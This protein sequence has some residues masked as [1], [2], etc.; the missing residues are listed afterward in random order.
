MTH[1]SNGSHAHVG[2]DETGQTVDEPRAKTIGEGPSI[3][4]GAEIVIVPFHGEHLQA[5]QDEGGGTVWVIVKRVCDALGLLAHPQ[6]E[7]LQ[8]KGWATTR[9][10]RVV[11]EDGKT[12]EMF[13]I[14]LDSLPMWLAT[15]EPSRVA[16]HVRPKLLVFQ[17]ECARAL[18]D[19]FFGRRRDSKD[20]QAFRSSVEALMATMGQTI[21]AL[22]DEVR[23]L[24]TDRSHDKGVIG[25][26]AARTVV[27]DPLLKIAEL[28]AY[29]AGE[30]RKAKSFRQKL[31]NLL[32][33][34]LGF[35]ISPGQGWAFL[36]ET[37]RGQATATIEMLKARQGKDFDKVF[38]QMR[39]A[40]GQ[41]SF[42]D[43]LD[44]MAAT[45]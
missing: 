1:D 14:S 27:L 31:D 39:A 2:N 22:T 17:K 44:Q 28:M 4:G 6:A 43:F 33:R 8:S 3:A 21:A 38:V 26:L 20:E 32:R 41:T 40:K 30:P 13:C 29:Q 19:H 7:K 11:A 24:R 25:T 23:A 37:K 9:M 35:P 12:R 5:T 42:H 36:P 10:N 18:A 16:E 34:D 45:P 15:I